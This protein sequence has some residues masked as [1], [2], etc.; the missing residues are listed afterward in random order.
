MSDQY[1]RLIRSEIRRADLKETGFLAILLRPND[2]VDLWVEAIREIADD[3]GANKVMITF[4][5]SEMHLPLLQ[6]SIDTV[7]EDDVESES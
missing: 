7:Q 1:Q 6:V 4:T 3:L 5:Y 2:R